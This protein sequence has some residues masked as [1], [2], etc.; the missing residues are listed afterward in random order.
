MTVWQFWRNVGILK[1]V[2]DIFP[3]VLIQK[4]QK[5]KAVENLLRPA[6]LSAQLVREGKLRESFGMFFFFLLFF[7]LDTKETKNQGCRKFTKA[8]R[9][10]SATCEGGKATGVVWYVF[11]LSSFLLS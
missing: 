2:V 4:K 6:D 9:S 10:V 5:I 8:S 3:F 1:G 7:C 11:F